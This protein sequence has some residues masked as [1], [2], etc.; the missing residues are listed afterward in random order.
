MQGV[1]MLNRLSSSEI[2]ALRWLVDE[3]VRRGGLRNGPIQIR[4][5]GIWYE[6]APPP[7]FGGPVSVRVAGTGTVIW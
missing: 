1:T 7:D 4:F 2:K 6:V 5:K 3:A